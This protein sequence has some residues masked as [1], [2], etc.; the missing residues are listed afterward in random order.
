[1]EQCQQYARSQHPSAVDE[2]ASPVK[3]SEIAA[4][5]ARESTVCAA[6]ELQLTTLQ[7]WIQAQ[8]KVAR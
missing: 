8:Q 2:T 3:L 7:G 4:E 1:M 5:H 6:T